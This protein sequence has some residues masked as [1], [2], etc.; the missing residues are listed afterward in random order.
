M[1][2]RSNEKTEAEEVSARLKNGLALNASFFGRSRMKNSL[3]K[4][5]IADGLK[6]SSGRNEPERSLMIKCLKVGRP[7]PT[8]WLT[9]LR[10]AAR[11]RARESVLKMSFN[12]RT[13]TT[14]TAATRRQLNLRGQ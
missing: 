7:A 9:K 3:L 14:T 1:K 12:Y 8:C 5:S 13:Q 2:L 10:A 11:V 4:C 6:I